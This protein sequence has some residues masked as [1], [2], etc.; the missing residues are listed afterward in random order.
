M[1]IIYFIPILESG[2]T[3]D[4]NASSL[5]STAAAPA[6]ASDPASGPSAAQLREVERECESLRV[7]LEAVR[8]QC[9]EYQQLGSEMEAHIASLTQERE[10]LTQAHAAEKDD[11]N[12]RK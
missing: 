9:A 6:S 10:Q 2:E 12:Q 1:D 4:P 8:K 7:S 5:S 11:A 3:A